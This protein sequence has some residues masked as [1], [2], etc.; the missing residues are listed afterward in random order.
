MSFSVVVAAA[1]IGSRFGP[2]VAKQYR[3]IAG[4]PVI[5]HTLTRLLSTDATRIVV[6]L[7]PEDRHWRS[8]SVF[9]NSRV[10]V[11]TGGDTRAR[12]VMGG[13]RALE[14]R[15]ASEDW[16][17]VHDVARPC[18]TVT[19]INRLFSLV[20]EHPVGGLLAAPVADTIKRVGVNHLVVATEDRAQFWSAFTP[21]MFRFGLL[22]DALTVAEADNWVAT[23]ESA[24]VERMGYRPLVVEGRRD[25]IKLTRPEDLP[26]IEA[27]LRQ[28]ALESGTLQQQQHQVQQ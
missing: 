17:L 5:A 25:N 23:D 13:L 4:R 26:L 6:A 8:L 1:G 14:S 2:G 22:L 18:V 11:I 12:S 24:A 21:Q 7:H 28:Q 20:Q 10:Q 3:N 16:V 19:D 15:L 9:S 27:V